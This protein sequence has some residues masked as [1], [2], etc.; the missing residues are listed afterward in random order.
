[1][2]GDS[3]DEWRSYGHNMTGESASK[4]ILIAVLSLRPQ[5]EAN[6]A[7]GHGNYPIGHVS[8]LLRVRAV[9]SKPANTGKDKKLP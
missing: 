3:C 1:M 9:N 2:I 4:A 5:T 6:M 7:N 8:L